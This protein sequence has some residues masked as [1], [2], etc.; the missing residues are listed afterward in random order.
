MSDIIKKASAQWQGSIKEGKGSISTESGALKEQPFGFNTRFEDKPG[1]NPEELIGAALAACYSMALSG[2][3]GKKDVQ[4]N[5]LDT[6]AEVVLSEQG[7]GFAVTRIN[8]VC[9]AALDGIE[10][11]DFEQLA[12]DT[13]DNCP[14]GKLL[15][16]GAQIDLKAS[17]A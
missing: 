6:S 17:L 16:A 2:A 3:L 10:E 13:K 5:S 9:N 8:L 12:A 14:M 1:T 4:I 15:G 7:E 11:S